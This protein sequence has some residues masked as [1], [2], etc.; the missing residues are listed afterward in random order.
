MKVRLLTLIM[1][2]VVIL[3]SITISAENAIDSGTLIGMIGDEVSLE[4][5]AGVSSNSGLDD[6]FRS[7]DLISS[8]RNFSTDSFPEL[9]NMHFSL[10][11][12]HSI[13]F[14]TDLFS[15]DFRA[16]LFLSEFEYIEI[17]STGKVFTSDEGT[18]KNRVFLMDLANTSDYSFVQVRVDYDRG[19]NR[20]SDVIIDDVATISIILQNTLTE[21]LL[22][23]E[24]NINEEVAHMMLKGATLIDAERFF[25]MFDVN[26]N[27]ITPV[28]RPALN[29]SG[30]LEKDGSF[31]VEAFVEGQEVV[32]QFELDQIE[33]FLDYMYAGVAP[34]WAPFRSWNSFFNDLHH[35]GDTNVDWW[36]I[37]RNLIIP[38]ENQLNTWQHAYIWNEY[39]ISSHVR[40]NG[41]NERIIEIIKIELIHRFNFATDSHVTA[42]VTHVYTLIHNTNRGGWVDVWFHNAGPQVDTFQLW[43]RKTANANPRAVFITR[44]VNGSFRSTPN[45]LA[46]AVGLV[47]VAGD[48]FNTWQH[49]SD[50]ENQPRGALQNNG[51]GVF[52]SSFQ[53]QMN[54]RGQAIRAIHVN[55]ES[56]VLDRRFHS[57]SISGRHCPEG[58]AHTT[59]FDWSYSV[60]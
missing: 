54:R 28:E 4:N 39:S 56:S 31:S 35:H 19:G 27:L 46:A 33:V 25:K 2:W 7:A 44:Q 30:A 14:R 37:N 12:M 20:R 29:I 22:H 38:P 5:I 48:V 9:R 24:S 59:T 40:P 55:S 49:L 10:Y 21:Q 45:F 16:D 11:D 3:G 41:S 57:I 1:V 26:Q 17:I 23:F 52:P 42:N 32:V 47:P 18:M 6:L 8:A 58:R 34:A 60:R 53:D 13:D 50:R 43:I 51:P 36:N 15:I